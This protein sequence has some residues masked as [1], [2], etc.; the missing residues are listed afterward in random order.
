MEANAI[1][2]VLVLS[3]GRCG[4]TML[5]DVL[6][7]HAEVLSLSEFFTSL[8]LQSSRPNRQA[9]TTAGWQWTVFSNRILRP[10][11]AGLQKESRHTGRREMADRDVAVAV[12]RAR[13]RRGVVQLVR[14]SNGRSGHGLA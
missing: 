12:C 13:A 5:S 3:T 11:N 1:A 4:S 9:L 8:G 7:T 14:A 10:F 2:P 6:N